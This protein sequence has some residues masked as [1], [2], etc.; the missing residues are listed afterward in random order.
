[1]MLVFSMVLACADPP[2]AEKP[3][4]PEQLLERLEALGDLVPF[5]P[6]P[7]GA[8]LVATMVRDGGS[9]PFHYY[10]AEPADAFSSA[11]LMAPQTAS[12]AGG[13]LKLSLTGEVCVTPELAKGHFGWAHGVAP[14]HAGPAV[15]Q[16]F[17]KHQLGWGDLKMRYD[18]KTGCLVEAILNA[19]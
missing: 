15:Q 19:K 10:N 1:M 8:A 18:D 4:T 6:D 3:M 2:L 17:L 7:V 12:A 9:G 13:M 14:N 5:A 16:R 11:W